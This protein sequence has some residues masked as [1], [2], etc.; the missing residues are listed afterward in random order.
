MGFFSDIVTTSAATDTAVTADVYINGALQPY[1]A[2]TAIEETLGLVPGRAMLQ[3]RGETLTITGPFNLN[4]YDW[5]SFMRYGARVTVQR[6]DEV[7]FAGVLLIRADNGQHDSI[8]WIALDDRWLL[9]RLPVRG[10]LVYDNN[11]VSLF[12]RFRPRLNPSGALNCIGASVGG[13]TWP[14][15]A[16]VAEKNKGHDVTDDV[17][18]EALSDGVVTAWT[19][20]RA[21]MYLYLLMHTD[22]NGWNA[23]SNARNLLTSERISWSETAADELSGDVDGSGDPLDRKC[24]DE[25]LRG[26]VLLALGKVLKMAGT[27]ELRMLPQY[28]SGVSEVRFADIAKEP[29]DAL[30]IPLLRGGDAD[31]VNTA[32]DFELHESAQDTAEAVL[33]EGEVRKLETD[34]IYDPGESG[35]T[36][37]PAWTATR[38][39]HFQTVIWGAASGQSKGEFALFPSTYG[40]APTLQADGLSG[41][42]FARACTDE[43]IALARQLYPEVLVEFEVDSDA[44]FTAGALKGYPSAGG[45]P[46]FDDV[47]THPILRESR[48]VF[49]K[50]L[51]H[52][53]MGANTLPTGYP[54]RVRIETSDG[55]VDAPYASGFRPGATSFRLSGLAEMANLD[56]WCIYGG[57]LREDPHEITVRAVRINAAMPMDHRTSA[58]AGLA[59]HEE[60]VFDP[61]LLVEFG[62]PVMDYLDAGGYRDDYQFKSK[63]SPLVTPPNTGVTINSDGITGYVAPGSEYGQALKGAERKLAGSRWVK[64]RSSW[65][66]VGIR[67]EYRP[68]LWVRKVVIRGGAAGD[69]DYWISAPVRTVVFDFLR[70]TT[71]VGGLLSELYGQARGGSEAPVPAAAA[72]AA[73][74]PGAALPVP[75]GIP[76]AEA[77]GSVPFADEDPGRGG[78]PADP[79]P[80]GRRIPDA[81]ED[82]PDW[83]RALRR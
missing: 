3:L 9:S 54:V 75:A 15:F 29:E 50:Q 11:V 43:A 48:P 38:L 42:P 82:M 64:R 33:L 58:Y 81:V 80:S 7:L 27:H 83:A 45:T 59:A 79:N 16:P 31:D 19:P 41:R 73:A 49:P 10:A 66:M 32:Y 17:F 68:G 57:D 2:C 37:L 14:V 61:S 20:R 28:G 69:L 5:V 74:D 63:P 76:E 70:Q 40:A 46:A 8:T 34:L 4:R 24:P 26:S 67:S 47:T 78:S 77:G 1:L 71:N 23:E 51:Q 22:Q 6:G 44:L 55:W 52:I 13:R 56:P 18:D 65:K 35:N 62:G 30:D 39:S 36:I 21:L 25:T 12:T 60:G 72:E 53:L